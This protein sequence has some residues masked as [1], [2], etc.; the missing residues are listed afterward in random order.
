MISN[1]NDTGSSS[2]DFGPLDDTDAS[3]WSVSDSDYVPI[4]SSDD[5]CFMR[6][7]SQDNK[8][9]DLAAKN[10]SRQARQDKRTKF[11]VEIKQRDA[12]IRQIAAGQKEKAKQKAQ[13]KKKYESLNKHPL[14]NKSG[15][16]S[17]SGKH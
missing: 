9:F 4:D 5:D 15:A 1:P 10:N 2:E 3:D 14:F 8:L 6:E 17:S 16:A 12:E 7:N 13:P 11:G